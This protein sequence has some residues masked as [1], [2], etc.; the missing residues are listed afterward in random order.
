MNGFFTKVLSAFLFLF[1]FNFIVSC[2]MDDCPP[3]ILYY[4]KDV[5]VKPIHKIDNG[6]SGY[7]I[8][9]TDTLWQQIAFEVR[10]EVEFAALERKKDY[11]LMNV[12]YGECAGNYPLNPALEDKSVF[13]CD[14]PIYWNGT[15]LEANTNLLEHPEFRSFVQF[16]TFFD[17][18]GYTIVEI[19]AENIK[20]P[21]DYYTF[22]FEWETDDN[23]ILSDEV[24]VYIQR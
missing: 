18:E 3:P 8:Q 14:K 22:Y 11:G 15:T 7:N 20:F 23:T 21:N 10:P 6:N 16:P 9:Y 4:L 13:S 2:V 5:N 1:T 24:T 17:Y 12:A 19:Q